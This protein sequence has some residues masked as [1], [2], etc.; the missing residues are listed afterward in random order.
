VEIADEL[1]SI[2]IDLDEDIVVVD[3][4]NYENYIIDYL[5]I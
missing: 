1:D 5:V 2:I 3:R 4:Y